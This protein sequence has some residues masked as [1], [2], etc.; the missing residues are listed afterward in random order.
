MSILGKS[1]KY[2]NEGNVHIVLHILETNYVLRLIKEDGNPVDLK[3]IRRSVDFVNL[4]MIPLLAINDHYLQDIVEIPANELIELSRN[5]VDF[6][7]NHRKFKSALSSYAIKD[8][9][10]AI[11]N[12]NSDTN[13]CIELKPKEGFMSPHFKK[14]SKCYYCLKQ[15]LKL[16]ERQIDQISDYC[17]LDLFSGDTHRMKIALINLIRNP[18]NN[19]KVFKNGH[20][21]YDEKSSQTVLENTI[22]DMKVFGGSLNIF[23]DFIIEILLSGYDKCHSILKESEGLPIEQTIESRRTHCDTENSLNSTSFLHKLL[24]LQK[25][26]EYLQLDTKNSKEDYDYV[27]TVIDRV[28]KQKIDL[29]IAENRNTFISTTDPE[30]LGP[31]SAVAKDC[32]IMISFSTSFEEGFSTIQ[33]GEHKVPFRISITDLEPKP[34]KTLVKRVR[35]ERKLIEIYEQHLS[36]AQK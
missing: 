19:F 27:H 25:L 21:I 29:K 15:F 22:K 35:T 4:V 34:M 32:S 12:A 5:L 31:I 17:P 6:R 13:F 1:W 20:I 23:L 33:I 24:Y 7:P 11:L 36:S 16:Q 14:F 3:T 30:I 8:I 10:L 9:N 2:I 18:Q 28:K 26:S